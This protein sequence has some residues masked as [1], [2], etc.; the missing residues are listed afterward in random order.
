MTIS[1]EPNELLTLRALSA[2]YPTIETALAEIAALRATL[3][4][5]QPVVHVISDVH[6]EY[7]KLRHVINNAS[8]TLRPFVE[9]IFAERLS[10]IELHELITVLYYPREEMEHLRPQLQDENDRRDWVAQTLRHQFELVRA[11]ARTRRR[12]EVFALFPAAHHELFE[13]LYG[14]VTMGRNES[15]VDTM[16]ET[17][18]ARNCDFELVREASHIVR[19]LTISELIVAGD[20]SDRGERGDKVIGYL[21]EQP[22]VR[23]TWGNH[24]ASWMGACLGSDVCIA[25]VVRIS[26]RYRRLSQ[27]EEGYSIIMSPLEKLAREV[28]ADDP[29]EFFKTKGKGLR[30]DL[31]MARMQKAMA[32]IQFK[33]EAQSSWRHPEWNMEHRNLLHRINF[34]DATVEI[35]GKTYA[36]RDT[37]LPTVDSSNPYELSAD[38]R[39]CMNRL[40][41]SFVTSD[42]LWQQ[43]KFVVKRGTMWLRRDDALIFH[44][45]VPIDSKGELIPLEIDGESL[46]GR[47]QFDAI[48]NLIRRSF[49]ATAEHMDEKDGDW[50]W[51]LWNGADSPLFGKDKMATFE[52]YFIADKTS[53]EEKKN[54][55]FSMIHDAEFCKRIG[56]EFGM[57]ENVLIVNGHVPV[58][59]EKGEDPVKRGGNAVTIDGAFSEAYGDHGYTL[60]LAQDKI[61]LAEHHHFDSIQDAITTGADIVPKTRTLREYNPSRTI[62]DSEDGISNVQKINALESL[63]NAYEEC[64][65]IE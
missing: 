13:E 30:D 51:Y 54:P 5:P 44:A 12:K 23:F 11:L 41:Q 50:F 31:L 27:L 14:E 9:K 4:L 57:N 28:Y 40:R 38:E 36:L 64:A 52:T 62:A 26:L 47:A 56:A 15:Y 1:F 58:K 8:G 37:H 59:I 20:L 45:C 63:I 42:R 33:L 6:G 17:Y 2:T 46:S 21:M 3:M 53:Q 18:A 7:K 10:N 48:E 22:N 43:M 16:L 55:Y 19:D 65:L 29:V 34:K 25:T 61:A 60:I 49:R 32:V 24:D 39:A 35:D